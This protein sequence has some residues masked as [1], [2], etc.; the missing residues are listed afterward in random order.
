MSCHWYGFNLRVTLS[1]WETNFF[2]S[3]LVVHL[4]TEN[5]LKDL[6][7]I[8]NSYVPCRIILKVTIRNLKWIW[9]GVL[10]PSTPIP[11]PLSYFFCTINQILKWLKQRFCLFVVL[12][13]RSGCTHSLCGPSKIDGF[14]VIGV[15]VE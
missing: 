14:T 1:R 4:S 10:W 5:F 12:M 15:F 2:L 13:V 11:Y 9:T 7:P 3:N 8:P 6:V